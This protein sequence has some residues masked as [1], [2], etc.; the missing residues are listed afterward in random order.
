MLRP[1]CKLNR[2]IVEAGQLP[3]IFLHRFSHVPDQWCAYSADPCPE[4]A[5][6]QVPPLSMLC[7]NQS[8]QSLAPFARELSTA[9]RTDSVD[10]LGE[11]AA[12]WHRKCSLKF[13]GMLSPP[14]CSLGCRNGQ[15]GAAAKS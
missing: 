14:C 4:L 5:T 1:S 7:T 10:T 15:D 9:L 8:F 11:L 3:S 12:G 6:K 2:P 13:L